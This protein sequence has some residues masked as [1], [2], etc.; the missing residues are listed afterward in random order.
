MN[1]A[2]GRVRNFPTA[3]DLEKALQAAGVPEHEL[4]APQQVLSTGLPT[5]IPVNA[6]SA[7]KLGVLEYRPKA[8]TEQ[9]RWACCL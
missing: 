4:N 2:R 7:K 9:S 8:V 1:G 6:T 5:F 3:H